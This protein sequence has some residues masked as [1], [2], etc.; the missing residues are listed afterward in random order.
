MALHLYKS[1]WQRGRQGCFLFLRGALAGELGG[2]RRV[3]CWARWDAV[4]WPLGSVGRGA[5]AG[6]LGGVG[7]V[8]RQARW[9]AARWPLGSVR[10]DALRLHK[11]PWQ[12]GKQGCSLLQR[13]VLAGERGET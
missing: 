10:R 12:R 5:L 11:S 6:E 13:S 3:G 9:G 4:R 1:P 8:G 2:A 7:C